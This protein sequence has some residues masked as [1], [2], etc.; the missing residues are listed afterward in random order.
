MEVVLN[1]YT[2]FITFLFSLEIVQQMF[3]FIA[4]SFVFT[5]IYYVVIKSFQY[6][7]DNIG[8]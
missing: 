7:N 8:C 3:W 4:I 2:T 5:N 1:L 6:L